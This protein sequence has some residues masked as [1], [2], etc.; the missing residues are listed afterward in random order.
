MPSFAVGSTA[1]KIAPLLREG[2]LVANAGKGLEENTFRRFT[3][4]IAG[5]L[6]QARVTALSGPS[7]AE[8]VARGVPTSVVSASR[9]IAAGCV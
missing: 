2:T 3:E 1:Q 7:H 5:E 4:V 8:E 9:D 6:P